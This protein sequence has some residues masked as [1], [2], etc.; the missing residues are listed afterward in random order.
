[1]H[2]CLGSEFFLAEGGVES[3]APE[4][5]GEAGQWLGKLRGWGRLQVAIVQTRS[6]LGNRHNGT[7]V[8]NTAQRTTPQN[9][10]R[11]FPDPWN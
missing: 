3:S 8:A 9:A 11:T 2:F 1:M 4:V 6:R 10:E 5:G 7:S